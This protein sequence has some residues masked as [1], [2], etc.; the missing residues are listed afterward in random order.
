MVHHSSHSEVASGYFLRE[1][2]NYAK[3]VRW[4]QV[5]AEKTSVFTHVDTHKH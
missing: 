5:H 3:S 1:L 2:D 4:R